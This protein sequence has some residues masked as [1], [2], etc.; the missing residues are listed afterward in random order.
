MVLRQSTLVAG[1]PAQAAATNDNDKEALVRPCTESDSCQIEK[2]DVLVGC[3]GTHEGKLLR[4]DEI[5]G[6]N[7]AAFTPVEETAFQKWVFTEVGEKVVIKF[8]QGGHRVWDGEQTDEF[9]F[10][11]SVEARRTVVQAMYC[12]VCEC[13]LPM[14]RIYREEDLPYDS[15]YYWRAGP[16]Y[17]GRRSP[18]RLLTAM[19]ACEWCY[20]EHPQQGVL[21]RLVR[22][23]VRARA[24]VSYWSELAH[25]PKYA[26]RM[27]KEAYDDMNSVFQVADARARREKR[28]RD[29]EEPPK[30]PRSAYFFYSVVKRR[31][32]KQAYPDAKV[33]ELAK[34]MGEAW[35]RLSD[36]EKAEYEER[37]AKDKARYE[38]E[39]WGYTEKKVP[40]RERP[41]DTW[42]GF[43]SWGGSSWNSYHYF[44]QKEWRQLT[45]KP[46]HGAY[47]HGLRGSFRFTLKVRTKSRLRMRGCSEFAM[48]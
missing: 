29:R 33:A 37:A 9:E 32:F 11:P 38:R 22:E 35:S 41:R 10:H 30:K 12:D 1:P 44:E 21:W 26:E 6:D 19:D 18:P 24:I 40:K 14:A 7:V 16:M 47:W 2:G 42:H 20:A 28:R 39:M 31:G 13:R 5:R 15:F 17:R 43:R 4:V 25:R 48:M 8:D 45:F 27:A 34:R 3:N 46:C 36:E 23:H